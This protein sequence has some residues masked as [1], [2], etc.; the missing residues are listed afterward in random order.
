MA[1]P[2]KPQN[3]TTP[4]LQPVRAFNSA[5]T[6][7]VRIA[8]PEELPAILTTME[9]EGWQLIHIVPCAGFNHAAYF[10]RVA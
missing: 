3:S 1:K 10:R 4:P 7:T 5:L 8:T 2:S 9:H 6:H